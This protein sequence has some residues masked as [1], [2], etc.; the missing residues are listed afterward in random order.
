MAGIGVGPI[1]LDFDDAAA[2]ERFP[3]G[4]AFEH[5]GFV[6]FAGETPGRGEIDEDGAALLQLV[7]RRSGVNGIQS[8][9]VGASVEAR[10]AS[11]P[12]FFADEIIA[13]AEHEQEHQHERDE[14][15]ARTRQ[16]GRRMRLSSSRRH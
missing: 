15:R 10:R 12:E 2:L 8:P 6:E 7:C 5:G 9:S 1:G 16:S 3:D 11:S 13:A 14:P 4:G